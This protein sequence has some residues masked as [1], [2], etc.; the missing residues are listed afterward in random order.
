MD[1]ALNTKLLTHL[2]IMKQAGQY[3]VTLLF[4][5]KCLY[6]AM[7]WNKQIPAHWHPLMP[8]YKLC[9]SR[10]NN[11]IWVSSWVH[12]DSTPYRQFAHLPSPTRLVYCK[13]HLHAGEA[14]YVSPGRSY[15]DFEHHGLCIGMAVVL[16]RPT[17]TMHNTGP[18]Y[19]PMCMWH[20]CWLPSKA[21]PKTD[22]YCLN[23]QKAPF[24]GN[25][26]QFFWCEWWWKSCI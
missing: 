7:N 11:W 8:S 1:T 24:N 15:V 17:A 6:V 13:M 18:I 9:N 20:R 12:H 22:F 19:R 25:H 14:K 3:N 16:I 26:G 4:F 5:Q 23:T 21:M 10:Q 2:V